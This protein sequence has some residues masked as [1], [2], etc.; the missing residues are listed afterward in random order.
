[1]GDV[2]RPSVADPGD[3]CRVDVV[4]KSKVRLKE[5]LVEKRAF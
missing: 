5:W 4:G 3:M 1:V 2:G